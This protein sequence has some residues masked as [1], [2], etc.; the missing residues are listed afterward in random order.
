MMHLLR[1]SHI[2]IFSRSSRLHGYHYARSTIAKTCSMW[3]ALVTMII[4]RT[5]S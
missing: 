5:R 2:G 1:P 4:T 3:D